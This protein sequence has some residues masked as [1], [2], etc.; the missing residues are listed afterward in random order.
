MAVKNMK[1]IVRRPGG[2]YATKVVFQ[3]AS[4][5]DVFNIPRRTPF[6]DIQNLTDLQTDGYFRHKGLGGG[7][8]LQVSDELGGVNTAGSFTNLGL[9]LPRTEKLI[10]LA[11]MPSTTAV[12]LEISGNSRAGRDT[13]TVTL[14]AGSAGDLYEID[15]FDLGLLFEADEK[16]NVAITAKQ[17]VDLVLIARF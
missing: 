14:P 8:A 6:A 13:K 2:T 10:L 9:T 15:L 5:N 12:S 17:A 16:G 4:A 11:K 1:V 7:G 3:T